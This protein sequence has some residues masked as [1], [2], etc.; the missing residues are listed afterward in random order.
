MKKTHALKK[1]LSKDRAHFRGAIQKSKG[2]AQ[3]VRQ[4]PKPKPNGVFIG[5]RLDTKEIATISPE[6]LQTHMQII[7]ATGVGKSKFLEALA[8]QIIK[9]KSQ[10]A[11]VVLDPHGDLYHDILAYCVAHKIRDRLVILDPHEQQFRTGFN[12]MRRDQRSITY[13]SVMMLEGIK[14]CWGQETFHQTPRMARWLYNTIRSLVEAELTL[15][16]ATDLLDPHDNP[17]RNAVLPFVKDPIVKRDWQWYTSLTGPHAKNLREERTESAWNRIQMFLKFPEIAQMLTQ[18]RSVIDFGNILSQ[19]KILLVN[20]K[21]AGLMSRDESSLLGTLIINDI[22]AAAFQRDPEERRRC[23]LMIDEF[24]NF[25]TKDLCAILDGGRKF[26]LHLI[27]AHQHLAQLKQRDEEVYYSTLTNARTKVV[28]GG[29]STD[30]A[31]LMAKK[32]MRF[33]LMDVKQEL[34]RTVFRP[35]ESTRTI[36]SDSE[37]EVTHE[38]VMN[39]FGSG[40]VYSCEGGI[41]FDPAVLSSSEFDSRGES[42]G[43]GH[44]YSSSTV[45][46][47]FYEYH[48]EQELASR[49]FWRLD[50][51]LYRATMQLV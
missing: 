7:G 14:K 43:S 28:F 49:E 10:P 16:E 38:G 18:Q 9:A 26:G 4:P 42:S 41:F 24:Q 33:N 11:L 45:E 39:A 12:P 1:A 6:H 23:Y 3:V 19:G 47:P 21:H 2:W 25:V 46:A 48:E 31:E 37:G 20:L 22:V 27:L 30:D 29:L 35:V 36:T 17:V 44:S 5:R 40:R 15:A 8:R 50:E 13:Q 34:Y 32:V 51:H